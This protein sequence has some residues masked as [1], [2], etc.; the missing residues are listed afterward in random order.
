MN[1]LAVRVDKLSKRYQIGT[2]KRTHDSLKERLSDSLREMFGGQGVDAGE[3][4]LWS[5]RDVS[6]DVREGEAFGVIGPNGAGKST[7]LKILSRITE[8]TE[9]RAEILGRVGSLLEVGTGFHPDLSGRENVYL[10]GA[11]LGMRKT[12]IDA[13]F[14]EIVAFAGVERFLD[15]PIKRYSSGMYTRLAFAVA[16]HLEPEILIVDEVLAVGDSAFQKKC[17]GKMENV[18][19]LGRTVLFVSHNMAA[20]SRLC[21]RAVLLEGGRLVACGPSQDIVDQYMRNVEQLSQ[22]TLAERTDRLGSQALRFTGLELRDADGHAIPQAA[23]GQDVA[24]ALQYESRPGVNL[25]DVQIAV[26]IR[27]RFEERICSLATWV[28]KGG[29]LFH[30]LPARGVIVCQIPRLPFQPGRYSVNVWSAV[31]GEVADYIQAADMID[32]EAGD[33]FDTGRLPALHEGPV[34]VGHT[35][36]VADLHESTEVAGRSR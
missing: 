32:V 2:R 4:T 29:H 36:H 9:G 8:P 12:E 25:H 27:G 26:N 31:A 1:G 30:E 23:S 16:A 18:T 7:L 28:A 13:K 3:R 33:F 20:V 10:N 35:W 17:L 11:I 14:D 21:Q 15:T 34:L 6:F 19:K 5:L 22:L 24:L